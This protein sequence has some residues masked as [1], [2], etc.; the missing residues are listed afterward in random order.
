MTKRS[1]PALLQLVAPW[2]SR[3]FVVK[4]NASSSMSSANTTRPWAHFRPHQ[5]CSARW[6]DRWFPWRSP[7]QP[8]AR[9]FKRGVSAKIPLRSSL[10]YSFN[11]SGTRPNN[12]SPI[13]AG[14]RRSVKTYFL[15]RMPDLRIFYLTLRSATQK[16]QYSR[17]SLGLAC[18]Q[19]RV[20][21]GQ[22]RLRRSRQMPK[23][24]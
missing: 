21:T 2:R 14:E 12:L 9:N 8:H 13:P 6:R 10:P 7:R 11:M 3:E 24:P 18:R 1:L 19:N 4:I 22:K 16:L 5:P 23:Q 20:T 17:A 15:L